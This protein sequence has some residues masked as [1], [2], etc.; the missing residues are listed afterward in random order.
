MICVYQGVATTDFLLENVAREND[1]ASTLTLLDLGDAFHDSGFLDSQR[2]LGPEDGIR[3]AGFCSTFC[4]ARSAGFVEASGGLYVV[5]CLTIDEKEERRLERLLEV[6]DRLVDSRI[7]DSPRTTSGFVQ[8]STVGN[9]WSVFLEE[10]YD[11]FCEDEKVHVIHGSHERN[12]EDSL[13]AAWLRLPDISP[14]LSSSTSVLDLDPDGIFQPRE[15]RTR[16][17]ILYSLRLLATELA[18]GLLFLHER[19]IV[20]LDIRPANIM[21]THSGHVQIGNFGTAHVLPRLLPGLVDLSDVGSALAR[22]SLGFDSSVIS[23]TALEFDSGERERVD[24]DAEGDNGVFGSMILGLNDMMEITR[25]SAPELL[26]RDEQGRIVLDEKVDWWSLG[27]VM[28]ELGYGELNSDREVSYCC[29]E[30]KDFQDFLFQLAEERTERL[31]GI[32]ILKHRFLDMESTTWAETSDLRHPPCLALDSILF[33]CDSE[34]GKPNTLSANSASPSTILDDSSD[35]TKRPTPVRSASP[36]WED[37]SSDDSESDIQ[38]FPSSA[39]LYHDIRTRYLQGEATETSLLTKLAIRHNNDSG[40]GLIESLSLF[41]DP[42]LE[43]DEGD[44]G[45]SIRIRAPYWRGVDSIYELPLPPNSDYC[46]EGEKQVDMSIDE[47]V[48]LSL[49]QA[50][51]DNDD[52]LHHQKQ[53]TAKLRRE[54]IGIKRRVRRARGIS[55]APR[56]AVKLVSGFFH[57]AMSCW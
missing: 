46:G 20:H 1:E 51:N 57:A 49:L 25:Y 42:I 7:L 3:H 29:R 40:L 13:V 54:D 19:G 30:E 2:A 23:L 37:Y 34:Q 45:S 41:V 52:H 8:D 24:K 35:P 38:P 53:A 17:H 28:R 50:R 32:N 18:L 12:L 15:E 44:S 10:I 21:V 14:S 31:F 6:L 26:E 39:S 55:K 11:I 33:Q 16:Q 22:T 56:R 9:S 47:I 48:A 27:V 43:G 5:K 36:M 4:H